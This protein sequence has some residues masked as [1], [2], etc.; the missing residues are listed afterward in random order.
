[1]LKCILDSLLQ[2]KDFLSDIAAFEAAVVS[3]LI[4]LFFGTITTISKDY[5]SLVISKMC[6]RSRI[7][8]RIS[9]ITK[10]V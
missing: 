3:F 4:P 8:R 9:A 5:G 1:M 6:N 10:A 7:F 2:E